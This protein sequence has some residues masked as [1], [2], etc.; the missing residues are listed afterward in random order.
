MP[1]Y[2]V[3]KAGREPNAITFPCGVKI[4]DPSTGERIPN[5]FYACTNPPRIGRYLV[6]DSGNPLARSTGRKV[7]GKRMD[8]R[9]AHGELIARDKVVSG[10]MLEYERWEVFEDRSWVAV[11]LATGAV[12]DKSEG[13]P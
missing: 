10:K 2:D 5:T 13:V 8:L 12:V 1:T 4:V 7:S 11:S 6:D 9:T 3:R